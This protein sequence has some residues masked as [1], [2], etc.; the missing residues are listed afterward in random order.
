MSSFSTTLLPI[1][2]SYKTLLRKLL[3]KKLVEAH[4]KKLGIAREQ[5]IFDEDV[6]L[7]KKAH[8]VIADIEKQIAKITNEPLWHF[9]F[10]SFMEHLRNTLKCYQL[11]NGTVIHP[12]QIASISI[13]EAIQVISLCP[14][15]LGPCIQDIIKYGSFEQKKKT[16]TILEK[17]L[18]KNPPSSQKLTKQLK[19]YL[20]LLSDNL[21]IAE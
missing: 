9:G 11:E 21:Q 19:T 15:K 20:Q 12:R 1:L 10:A 4:V 17:V 18:I 6:E 8:N 16:I 5:I 7:Y 3:P 2:N 13:I 14:E